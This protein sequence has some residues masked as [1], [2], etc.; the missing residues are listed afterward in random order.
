[1]AVE[2]EKPTRI[3]SL[4]ANVPEAP[5][6]VRAEAEEKIKAELLK[7][8]SLE[9]VRSLVQFIRNGGLNKAASPHDPPD[10][11]DEYGRN[12]RRMVHLM[13]VVGPGGTV[14]QEDRPMAPSLKKAREARP[15]ADYFDPDEKIWILYGFKRQKSRPENNVGYEGGPPR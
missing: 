3:S 10:E 15:H 1:M 5:N 14:R 6:E 2:L 9:E 11:F 8:I 4:V 12:F 7:D 13:D